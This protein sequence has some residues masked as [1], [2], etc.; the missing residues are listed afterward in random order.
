MS[1]NLSKMSDKELRS[2]VNRAEKEITKRKSNAKRDLQQKFKKIAAEH[3]L[4]LTDI[5]GAAKPRKPVAVKYRDNNGNSWTGRGRKPRWLQAALEKGN[6][7]DDYA[8]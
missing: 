4:S 8:I 1:V 7:L 3:G 2:L 6:S 5:V